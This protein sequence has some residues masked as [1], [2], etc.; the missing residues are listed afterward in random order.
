MNAQ[1]EYT[2]MNRYGKMV[3]L[4]LAVGYFVFALT[5]SGAFKGEMFANLALEHQKG[6]VISSGWEE[7]LEFKADY[8]DLERLEMSIYNPMGRTAQG[9]MN[10]W[11]SDQQGKKVWQETVDF[12]R[13]TAAKH[14]RGVK[15]TVVYV[16]KKL[17]K[18][19]TYTLHLK[20]VDGAREQNIKVKSRNITIF[21]NG[22]NVKKYSM[23]LCAILLSMVLIFVPNKLKE[24]WNHWFSRALFLVTP[25]FCYVLVER[26]SSSGL[27][28]IGWKYG[29]F[30]LLVYCT[31][32]MLFYAITNRTRWAIIFTVLC[33]SGLGLANFYVTKFRG[34]SLMPVDFATAGTAAN[35]A[36]EYSYEV[37][38]AILWNGVLILWFLFATLR[39]QCASGFHLKKRV[40][41]IGI[42]AALFA[43]CVSIFGNTERLGKFGIR[44]KV[45]NPTV[46]CKRYGYASIFASS[47]KFLIVEKPS[48]YSKDKVNQIMKPYVKQAAQENKKT[49]GK[50]PNV[51]AIMNEAFSDLTVLGDFE[52]NQDA[53]PFVRN[54]KKNTVKGT[55]YMSSYGGQTAN[56]EFEFLTGNS[57]AFLPGGSVAYQYQVKDQLGGLTTTLKNQGYQGNLVLHPYKAN[58]YNREKVYPLLGFS[59][60]LSI[61][62][63]DNPELIRNYISDQEDFEKIISQYEAAKKESSDPF[64]MFNVTIQN[65]GGYDQ[66]FSNFQQEI[67]VTDSSGTPAVNRYLSLVKKTDEAFENLI[68]YFQKVK[69]PTI[70]VMFGDHQPKLSDSFYQTVMAKDQSSALIREQK[71]H[72][73]PFVIWANYD[74]KEEEI[75]AI[76]PNY[77]GTKVIEIS[78]NEKTPYECY[79]QE[80]YKKYPVVTGS[81]YMDH[82]GV[83]HEISNLKELPDDLKEYQMVQYYHMFEKDDRNDSFFYLNESGG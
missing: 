23:L 15:G 57:M 1:K 68:S 35:V 72:Q 66:D 53:M 14:D 25:M 64:Y 10:C 26:F 6:D 71:K 65:H 39:L 3:C 13:L 47:V 27:R 7:S 12:K 5:Q 34:T 62:S 16:K 11:I 17:E 43:V 29:L 55:M 30:N 81:V 38:T 73:V 52:T 75:Q 28:Y 58:G 78:S 46:S 56:S 32:L 45:W 8:A 51:I 77:L 37:N 54:L 9:E 19:E 49:A 59:K 82:K 33:T 61:D 44:V 2:Q 60:Y 74:I 69:E 21:Y 40:L 18:N 36:T 67:K 80:L 31:V 70:I 48:G 76:S 4:L 42:F 63:F 50:K 83:L 41:P 22:F 24:T 20:A 79:L